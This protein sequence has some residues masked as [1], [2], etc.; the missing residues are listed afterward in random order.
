MVIQFSDY[1]ILLLVVARH[2][3]PDP[4]RHSSDKEAS[5]P[6]HGH[7]EAMDFPGRQI[8]IRLAV[9]LVSE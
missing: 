7:C 6:N 9:Q 4:I 5:E 2:R 3:I 1:D 8:K